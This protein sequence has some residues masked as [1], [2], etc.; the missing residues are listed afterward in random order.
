M[1]EIRVVQSIVRNHT[2]AQA[3]EAQAQ[4]LIDAWQRVQP[5]AGVSNT[6][7]LEQWL[8]E[9]VEAIADWLEQQGES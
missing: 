4:R 5:L 6:E 7:D 3:T 2:S 1:L 9:R 8:L